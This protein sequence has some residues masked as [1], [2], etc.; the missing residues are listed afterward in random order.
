M[1]K[2]D[3]TAEYREY[4]G[5]VF[6]PAYR[7]HWGIDNRQQIVYLLSYLFDSEYGNSLISLPLR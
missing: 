7:G 6:V 4:N 2:C 1:S 3:V 5:S